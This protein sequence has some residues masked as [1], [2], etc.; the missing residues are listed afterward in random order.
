MLLSLTRVPADPEHLGTPW[1]QERQ[2]ASRS[3]ELRKEE[4]AGGCIKLVPRNCAKICSDIRPK[5]P[6]PAPWRPPGGLWRPWGGPGAQVNLL[7]KC[8]VHM[9]SHLGSNSSK[10]Q[11]QLKPGVELRLLTSSWTSGSLRGHFLGLCW[12]HLGLLMGAREAG[13]LKNKSL[14]M[15][16][17]ITY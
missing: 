12:G 1:Q 16:K 10:M 3:R 2:A 8:G 14:K 11:A 17:T 15:L 9:R 13:F 4:T 7:S 6:Q 5:G